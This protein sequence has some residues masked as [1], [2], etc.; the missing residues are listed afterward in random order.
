[1]SVLTGSAG[2]IGELIP[3]PYAWTNLSTG[4]GDTVLS[5]ATTNA[6]LYAGGNFS[7]FGEETGIERIAKWNGASWTN[8][9]SGDN[10]QAVRALALGTNG[11]LYAGGDFAQMGGEAASKVAKWDGT[12][13]SNLDDGVGNA[14]YALACGTNG[15]L[16]AGGSFTTAGGEAASK[17]AKWDGTSWTNLG[18]GFNEYVRA[19]AIGPDGELYAGGAFTNSGGLAVSRVAKWDG[20]AWTNLGDG[21]NDTVWALACGTNGNLYAGGGFTTAGGEAASRVAIWASTQIE[22]P[23]VNPGNGPIAG[24]TRVTIT[25]N[26]LSDDSADDIT[27]V[28]FCG[29]AVTNVES[30][31]STQVVVWTGAGSVGLG[32]V[33][34]FSI[35]QGETVKSNIFTYIGAEIAILGINGDE[36]TN[37]EGA[38]VAKGTDFGSRSLGRAWTNTFTVTNSSSDVALTITGITTNGDGAA[39]FRVTGLPETV[40]T[41]TA[42]NFSLV[43]DA[44]VEGV[45]TAMIVIANNSDTPDYSFG[46]KGTVMSAGT[47]GGV[48]PGPYAWTNL[49]TGVGNTVL[50][51]ATTNADLYAGGNFSTFGEETDVERIAQWDGTAWSKMGVGANNQAVRALA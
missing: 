14:T 36:I 12:V 42:S 45:S 8:L 31:C 15:E 28:T 7:T 39:R 49:S 48:V 18:D 27:N 23:G 6:D 35:S 30:Q 47:I 5:L 46:V 3:G 22:T 34:V 21:V 20:T 11:E 13:W 43:F 38:I 2:M 19:L 10:N 24:G 4:I 25:G 44:S 40:Q 16:Y 37:G 41:G 32:D 33:R 51:L 17:I 29:V 9:G 1:M 50:A 26:G